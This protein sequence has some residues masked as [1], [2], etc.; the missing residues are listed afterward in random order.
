MVKR[1]SAYLCLAAGVAGLALPVLPGIPLLIIGL[2][3]LGPD[4]PLR[5][6]VARLARRKT[7]K[8]S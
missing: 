4:H 8:G 5:K 3:L 6:T 7:E 1:I 2:G